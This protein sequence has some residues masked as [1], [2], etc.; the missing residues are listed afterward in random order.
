MRPGQMLKR[1]SFSV[2]VFCTLVQ[3]DLVPSRGRRASC[4]GQEMARS[5]E[6]L[7]LNDVLLRGNR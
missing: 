1:V 5:H 3:G 4:A 2:S 6:E 7:K